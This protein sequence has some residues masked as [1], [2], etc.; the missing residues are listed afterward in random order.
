MKKFIASI[1]ALVMLFSLTACANSGTTTPAAEA[2]AQAAPAQAA[3]A[4][5]APAEAA[6]VE[7]VVLRLNT[8]HTETFTT[9]LAIQHFADL[10]KERTNGAVEIVPYYNGVL[11]SNNECLEQAQYGGIDIT[12]AGG[13]ILAEYYKAFNALEMPYIYR[14]RDHYWSVLD[15]EIGMGILQNQALQDKGLYGLCFLDGGSRNFY[16]A[17]KEVHTPADMA[18]L[19]V[20]VQNSELMMGMVSAMGGNPTSMDSSEI[21]GSLSTGVID[22][23]E[24]NLPFYLSQS[25]YEVAPYITM[26]EHT[27][28]VDTLMMSKASMEKLTDEQCEIVKQAA[29]DASR[30]QREIWGEAET[31][32]MDQC[33]ELGCTITILT[34]E[35]KQ[36]FMDCVKELNAKMGADYVDILNAIAAK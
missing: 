14:D 3:P 21:Y 12:I 6:P 5:A 26:D 1:L 27:R 30:Y 8:N 4:E 25:H 24:N 15:S 2:P 22:A 10:V 9:S 34:P 13:S 28:A 35:E 19:V 18:S 31:E 23:A 20:R 7:P 29:L 36:Q 32:S 33:K 17:K 11:G 16:F